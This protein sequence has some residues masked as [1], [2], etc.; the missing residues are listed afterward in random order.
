[1]LSLLKLHY[2]KT[3]TSHQRLGMLDPC[4]HPFLPWGLQQEE[5]VDVLSSAQHS[6]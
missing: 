3:R 6:D 4:M 1:M 2:T 5:R